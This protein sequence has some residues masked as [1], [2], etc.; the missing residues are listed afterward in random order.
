M[1]KVALGPRYRDKV[2][3]KEE[4]TE[5]NRVVS[6]KLYE[7]VGSAEGL[8]DSTE[9]EKLQSIAEDE[10]RGAVEALRAAETSKPVE[11]GEQTGGREGDEAE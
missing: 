5:I 2:I 8:A 1:V 9:R 10:V 7:L 4:Y 6:R 11:D 3:T